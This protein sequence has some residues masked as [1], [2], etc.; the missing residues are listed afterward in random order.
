MEPFKRY[1]KQVTGLRIQIDVKFLSFTDILTKKEV[2]CFQYTAIDDAT[3]V[4]VLN[5]YDRHSQKNAIDFVDRVRKH[6]HFRIHTLQTDNGHEF[7]S[8]FH[9]HCEDLGIQ[10]VCIKKA[11]SHLNGKVER[12]HLTDKQE[13][14]HLVEYGDDIDI[15]KNL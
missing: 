12:S 8:Q 5:V 6:F 14:Y 7:Q 4:S 9:W 15:L 3:I 10:H 13:F 11:S 2:K 1:D